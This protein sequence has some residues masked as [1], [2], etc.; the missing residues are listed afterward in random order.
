MHRAE[1]GSQKNK[2]CHS[3][4]Q[5]QRS[6]YLIIR[7]SPTA[8]PLVNLENWTV[9]IKT[10]HGSRDL[11][12]GKNVLRPDSSKR[13]EIKVSALLALQNKY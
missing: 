2:F 3:L 8:P 6:I 9:Q 5:G 11:L 13:T 1:K 7:L 4:G 10:V 12:H